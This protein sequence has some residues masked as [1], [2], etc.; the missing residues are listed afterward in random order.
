MLS[1]MCC[2]ERNLLW[3][4]GK[5]SVVRF[6]WGTEEEVSIVTG[7]KVHTDE[8]MWLDLGVSRCVHQQEENG[9]SRIWSSGSLSAS[10]QVR[11]QA[12]FHETLK[13]G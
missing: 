13:K 12:G 11:G 7:L 3:R 5:S 1:V 6:L 10:G 4:C 2:K 8:L 9:S